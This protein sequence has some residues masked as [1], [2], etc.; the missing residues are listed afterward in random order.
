MTIAEMLVKL[1]IQDD[2]AAGFRT[3]LTN[4]QNFERQVERTFAATEVIDPAKVAQ[5]ATAA[6]ARVEEVL[7][8]S[9]GKVAL[10]AR[11]LLTTA[12]SDPSIVQSADKVFAR[13]A[14]QARATA[15]AIKAQQA[16]AIAAPGAGAVTASASALSALGLSARNA[17]SAAELVAPLAQAAAATSQLAAAVTGEAAAVEQAVTATEAFVGAQKRAFAAAQAGADAIAALPP[18]LRAVA[19]AYAFWNSEAGQT[20]RAVQ[21]ANAAAITSVQELTAAEEAFAASL[22]ETQAAA[23]GAAAAAGRLGEGVALSG[24][25]VTNLA[26]GLA[27]LGTS[28][29]GAEHGVTQLV[30]GL[31]F[32]A[33]EGPEVLAILTVVAGL[34]FAYEELTASSRRAAEEGQKAAAALAKGQGLYTPLAETVKGLASSTKDLADAQRT[35]GDLQTL[36]GKNPAQGAAAVGAIAGPLG[37]VIGLIGAYI[38]Q[39]H[40]LDKAQQASLSLQN[41]LKVA[42]SQTADELSREIAAR[43]KAIELG[44]ADAAQKQTALALV[45]SLISVTNTY[46]AATNTAADA[47]AK[48][49]AANEAAIALTRA[50]VN[51]RNDQLTLQNFLAPEATQL[52]NT[53]AAIAATVKDLEGAK[54]LDQQR[55]TLVQ[56]LTE[57][58]AKERALLHTD[59]FQQAA[60]T[61]AE[62]EVALNQ[63]AIAAERFRQALRGLS[64]QQ[65]DLLEVQRQRLLVDQAMAQAERDL[66]AI[67]PGSTQVVFDAAFLPGVQDAEKIFVHVSD[68]RVQ[69]AK[70]EKEISKEFRIQAD[71]VQAIFRN[72]DSGAGRALTTMIGLVAAAKEFSNALKAGDTLGQLQAAAGILGGFI[73]TL[74]G[75]FGGGP[76]AQEIAIKQNTDALNALSA[77]IRDLG[78]TSAGLET[79]RRAAQALSSAGLQGAIGGLS[80][81]DQQAGIDFVNWQ[82][83]QFGLTL[84]DLQ[85]IAQQNGLTLLDQDGRLVAASFADL[86]KAIELTIASTNRFADSVDGTRQQLELAQKLG[87]PGAPRDQLGLDQQLLGQL[88]PS[89]KAEID[90]AFAQGP[91][92]VRAELQKLFGLITQNFFVDNPAEL[93]GSFTD[94]TNAIGDTADQINKLGGA[95]N[96]AVTSL[97]NVPSGFKLA[98]AE[99]NATLDQAQDRL[100]KSLPRDPLAGVPTGRPGDGASLPIGPTTVINDNR[101]ITLQVTQQPGESQLELANRVVDAL[102]VKASGQSGDTLQTGS[103]D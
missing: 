92:A 18:G 43:A 3:A 63:G 65:Q 27:I 75:L 10:D 64:S 91:D 21:E 22:L 38:T 88:L 49:N 94:L 83:A 96:D 77:N 9:F 45:Q 25:G 47:I 84:A 41:G 19:E 89:F 74:Q 20:A 30:L 50:A 23:G 15:E 73:G 16:A 80:A 53:R 39:Q 60:F 52:A 2:T 102:R 79:A 55:V 51:A 82:L 85:K 59:E 76:S 98:A 70:T 7:A 67:N 32:F 57:L 81:F 28:A 12:V 86:Q 35:L 46:A 54:L 95:A 24:R 103:F 44:T 97:L 68:I 58:R 78:S 34:S 33:A 100:V 69:A 6:G 90:K 17:A 48:Q 72:I 37:Q 62:Q 1:G 29:L 42:F 66:A 5:Q 40:E 26:R 56:Q 11:T 4:I 61:I 87:L 13:I 99:F 93:K 31:A 101:Q 71:A 36:F 14:E 8:R